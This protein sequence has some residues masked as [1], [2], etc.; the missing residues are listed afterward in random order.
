MNQLAAI[1]EFGHADP[2]VFAG[3]GRSDERVFRA[4]VRHSRRVR[5]LRVAIPV[6]VAVAV[7]AALVATTW[8]KPLRALTKMPINV[9]HLV[10]SGTKITM[11][12]PRLA[13]YTN[14][15]RHYDLTA[16]AA[17]QDLT[18]PDVIELQGIRANVEMQDKISYEI[19]AQNG[20]FNNRTEMLI[21]QNNV[22]VVSSDGN[23]AKLSEAMVDIRGGKMISEKPVEVKGLEWTLNGN[24]VEIT[25]SGAF[26]RFDRGVTM[27]LMPAAARADG[28]RRAR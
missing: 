11:Q 16:Q 10:V 7:L 20:V 17:A 8:L 13:G 26:V 9:G 14:D 4:A 18:K 12:Q 25:E 5:V 1:S 21:L 3:A 19:T 24:R 6:S 27:T 23:R 28:E 15:N 22:V 2:Q